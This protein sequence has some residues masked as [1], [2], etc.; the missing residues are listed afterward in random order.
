M[1]KKRKYKSDDIRK[2]IKVRFH[3]VLKNKIN[4]S[5]KNAGSTELF[6]FLPQFFISNIS[7]KFNYHE[8]RIHIQLEFIFTINL[9]TF[10]RGFIIIESFFYFYLR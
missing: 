5:L 7:K 8:F 2:K 1:K 4:E 9:T 3:K 10:I 6:S